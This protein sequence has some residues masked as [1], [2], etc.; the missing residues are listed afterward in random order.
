[1]FH[2]V[3]SIYV[4]AGLPRLFLFL[5]SCVLDHLL[6]TMLLLAVLL[7]SLFLLLLDFRQISNKLD[8]LS[9]FSHHSTCSAVKFTDTLFFYY[10]FWQSTLSRV[11]YRDN[12]RLLTADWKECWNFNEIIS[13][14]IQD[15]STKNFVLTQKWTY[16]YSGYA[17][18]LSIPIFI[19]S[20]PFSKNH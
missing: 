20:N 1:M 10:Y 16:G 4:A 7:G 3:N 11:T 19:N 17:V 13:L 5:F 15:Y 9:I 12:L 18:L 14:T 8:F 6:S 2:S